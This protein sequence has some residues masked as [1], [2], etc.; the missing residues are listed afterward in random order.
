MLDMADEIVE[1]LGENGEVERFAV[2]ASFELDD[3]KY[4]ILTKEGEEESF[5]FRVEEEDGEAV[6]VTIE[7]EDEL[8]EAI[9]AYE[10]LV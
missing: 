6:F 10:S 5:V 3:T 8:D 2:E 1:F 7:D 4:A 9:E